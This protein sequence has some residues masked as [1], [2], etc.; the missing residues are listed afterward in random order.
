MATVVS[1]VGYGLYSLSK[2]S[3]QS[4][5]SH[6]LTAFPVALREADEYLT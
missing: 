4:S 5:L 3:P 6:F 2:V 1:G